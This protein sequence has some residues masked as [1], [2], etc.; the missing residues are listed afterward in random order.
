MKDYEVEDKAILKAINKGRI[1]VCSEC[2]EVGER[3]E[4]FDAYFCKECN[5][6]LESICEVSC[7]C[8][9]GRPEKPL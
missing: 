8:C 4:K 7:K 9:K 1:P 3:N 6:W 5:E 2:R